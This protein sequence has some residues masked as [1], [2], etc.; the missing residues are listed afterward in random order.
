MTG[1]LHEV[2]I[3][4]Y[5]GSEVPEWL[6]FGETSP[7]RKNRIRKGALHGGWVC[8]LVVAVSLSVTLKS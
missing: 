3:G 8:F 7:V 5:C 2:N 6:R 4:L 1:H